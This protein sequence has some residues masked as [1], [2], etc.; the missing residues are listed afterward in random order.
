LGDDDEDEGI[1]SQMWTK[2]FQVGISFLNQPALQ[3]ENFSPYK[4]DRILSRYGDMRS[5]MG[6][7]I[8]SLW[9]KLGDNKSQFIPG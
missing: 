1:D 2:Y 8:L 7:Q 4:R 5:H 3:I 9:S 6:F